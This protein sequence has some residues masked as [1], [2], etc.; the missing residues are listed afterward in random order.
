MHFFLQV[1][2]LI[3]GEGYFTVTIHKSNNLTT[4]WRVKPN[5]EIG[6]NVK[7]ELLLHQLQEYFGGIG[8]FKKD[9]KSN[10]I[11]YSVLRPLRPTTWS[12]DQRVA[13]LKDILEIVIPL[14]HGA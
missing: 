9:I 13:D 12:Q 10:A 2:G 11:K 7:D 3:D 1:T 8:T 6:L 5:F 4:G 14:A